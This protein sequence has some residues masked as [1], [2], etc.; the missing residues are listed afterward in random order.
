MVNLYTYC[1]FNPV[2]SSDPEG[3]S[4]EWWE[5]LVGA[6]VIA[7][8]TSATVI[9]AG[10]AVAVLGASA[11]AISGAMMGAAIGGAVSGGVN[12]ITQ[13]VTQDSIDMGSLAFS[14]GV[15]GIIG[16]V[17]GGVGAMSR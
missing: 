12:M 9:T 7:T 15:G 6:A 13:A 2:I 11:A 14:T 4:A 5:L 1:G 3:T 17:S 16:V 8:V 10:A